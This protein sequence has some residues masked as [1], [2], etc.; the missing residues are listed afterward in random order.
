VL[1]QPGDRLPLAGAVADIGS[2]ALLA[3]RQGVGLRE[4]S[5]RDIE[6]DGEALAGTGA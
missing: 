2:Y 6:W 1:A 3:A 4:A 5:T